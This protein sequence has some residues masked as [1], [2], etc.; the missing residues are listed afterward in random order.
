MIQKNT[1]GHHNLYLTSS[2]WEGFYAKASP[3]ASPIASP[4]TLTE[5]LCLDGLHHITVEGKKTGGKETENCV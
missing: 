4:S 3:I 5:V 2:Y 1:I